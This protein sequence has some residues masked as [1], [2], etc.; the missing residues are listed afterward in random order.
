M[1]ISFHIRILCMYH[2]LSYILYFHITYLILS[3]TFIYILIL[4]IYGT[5]VCFN[6]VLFMYYTFICRLLFSSLSSFISMTYYILCTITYIVYYLIPISSLFSCSGY[7]P[8]LYFSFFIFHTCTIV[9]FY[10]ICF[11]LV[12]FIYCHHIL[13]IYF[14]YICTF[15]FYHILYAFIYF[16]YFSCIGL[17]PILSYHIFIFH[18]P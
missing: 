10:I 6:L 11:Y 1:L 9:Y 16:L 14:I 12:L 5:F 3:C 4:F 7:T 18:I 13:F 17:K 2:T 8:M 15:L